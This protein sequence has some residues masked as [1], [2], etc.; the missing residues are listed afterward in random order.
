M[1]FNIQ[2]FKSVEQLEKYMW[3]Y[4]FLRYF[5]PLIQLNKKCMHHFEKLLLI[6]CFIA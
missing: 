4:T 3:N 1:F 2:L 6:L 5:K